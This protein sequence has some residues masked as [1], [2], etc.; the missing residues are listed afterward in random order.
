MAKERLSSFLA[1]YQRRLNTLRA[2][3]VNQR[4][5]F[6]QRQF[7]QAKQNLA[8]SQMK[9]M[10]FQN[11]TGLVDADSQI[12]L[13]VQM[14]NDAEA[15]YNQTLSENQSYQA[16]IDTAL[17]SL[18]MT[19]ETAENS[20]HL[21]ENIEYQKFRDLIADVD[22]EISVARAAFNEEHPQIK[23]LYSKRQ[24]LQ[25]QLQRHLS[26]AIPGVAEQNVNT[27]LKGGASDS[28]IEAINDLI[29]LRM[30]SAGLTSRANELAEQIALLKSQRQ[31]INANRARDTDLQRQVEVAES[32][33][34]AV[35]AL[36]EQ[37]KTDP[38][39]AYPDVQILDEPTVNMTP[40]QPRNWL[41]V[42]G[43][44]L[45][46]TFGSAA[47]LLFS[48]SRQ[49]F[50]R[51]SDLEDVELPILMC[52]P[53]Q[54]SALWRRPLTTDV[55]IEFQQLAFKIHSLHIHD[56]RL[57]V[58]SAMT[59]EGKSM[60][61]LGLAMALVNFGFRVLIVDGDLRKRHLSRSLG[62]AN[63]T[64]NSDTNQ[65][66]PINLLLDLDLLVAPLIAV[67]Q[68][69]SFFTQG[70]FESHLNWAQEG[71]DYDYV[72]VDSSPIAQSIEATLMSK[73]VQ[74]VLFIVRQGV[75][76]RNSVLQSLE[77][78]NQ[79]RMIGVVMN[80][81]SDQKAPYSYHYKDRAQPSL[82]TPQN[83]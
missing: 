78:L 10:R 63:S 35:L 36:I 31:A 67:D 74:N 58:T 12:K 28:R 33:Y 45:A 5:Q 8:I 82:L 75:S 25:S 16:Q 19:P 26:E 60:T 17:A 59:G 73:I 42:I 53:H 21:A 40:T 23:E 51:F 15:A 6:Y 27:S 69:A 79:T 61:T 66:A 48:E 38:F 9:L 64:D 22:A 81:V 1:S 24:A 83:V 14:V 13:V 39:N 46:S 11:A 72:L 54:I 37:A 34:K 76:D 47:L 30:E 18:R 44:L 2:Q 68:M 20:L 49:P 62:Y 71:G 55:G 29:K 65:Q 77:Q 50:L 43:A 41:T 32:T 52:I 80:D 4:Q 56:S 7:L 3:Y 57:I 70:H